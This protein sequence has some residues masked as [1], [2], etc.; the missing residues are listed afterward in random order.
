MTIDEH[1][2]AAAVTERPTEV[3]LLREQVAL[4]AERE[5]QSRACVIA[6]LE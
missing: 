1:R 2:Q 6:T 3:Q 5:T 4:L